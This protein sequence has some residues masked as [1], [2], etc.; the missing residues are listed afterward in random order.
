M[1]VEGQNGDDT[2]YWVA[3]RL[4]D[5]GLSE[6][7]AGDLMLDEYNP[8]C[9]PPWSPEEIQ[10]KVTNAYRYATGEP[11]SA[12]PVVM[13]GPVAAVPQ[14]GKMNG[15]GVYAFG[16]MLAI[17]TIEAR[18]WIFGDV[19][20][21]RVVTALVAAGGGGKSTFVLTLAAHL[22]V[23]KDWMGMHPWRPGR[24]IIYNAE[25]ALDELSRRLNAICDAYEL[26]RD[27]VRSSIA[28]VSS[29]ELLLRITENRPPRVNDAQ[30]FALLEAASDP[31]VQLVAVDPLAEIHT[32]NENDN[33]EMNYV[34]G[35]LRVVA[36]RANCAV[37]AVQHTGKPPVASSVSWAGNQNAS[38]GASAVPAAARIVLTL[39]PA[40]EQDCDAIGVPESERHLYV[41]LDGAKANFSAKRGRPHWLRWH[42][43]EMANSDKVGVLLEHD[44]VTAHEAMTQGVGEVVYDELMKRAAAALGL[45][46]AVDAVRAASLLSAKEDRG[47]ARRRL[48]RVFVAPVRVA[49]GCSVRL[50]ATPQGQ[51]LV[52]G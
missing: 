14:V 17:G 26:D 24:S 51:K 34:M 12:S 9:V 13:F 45:D 6:G 52:I 43:R 32:A 36:R 10:S 42:E 48:Q 38:R 2:T 44:A 29:D 31:A 50:V 41:R 30:V 18:P 11:G 7:T 35:V 16:N 15:H 47:A 5:L 4:R 1:A 25:D 23:G 39:F 19:L 28:L 37:V 27:A 40:A 21:A 8:R 33:M 49:Q 3:C 22:A 20:M 46:E